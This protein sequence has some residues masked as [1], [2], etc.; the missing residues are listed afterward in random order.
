MKMLAILI[1]LAAVG[2]GIYVY[3]VEKKRDWRTDPK[4]A[5][6]YLIYL[7]ACGAGL[8]LYWLYMLVTNI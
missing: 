7:M 2:Y 1:L 6:Y 3:F 8:N 4:Y 5:K